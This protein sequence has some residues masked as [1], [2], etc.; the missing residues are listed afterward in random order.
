MQKLLVKQQEK[1]LEEEEQT[2]TPKEKTFRDLFAEAQT[3][4][5]YWDEWAI[6]DFT[7]ELS[8]RMEELGLTRTALAV[9]IKSS[10]AYVT[11][12]L[13]GDANFTLR[14]MT[15]LAR[16]VKSVLRVHLAPVGSYTRWIDVVDN[17]YVVPASNHIARIS[18]GGPDLSDY[19]VAA[20][21]ETSG[22][23]TREAVAGLGSS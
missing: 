19:T 20:M 18:F 22:A 2:A 10:P 1:L 17:T 13:R 6:G 12:I 15:K 5:A 14:S 4:D 3:H 9:R 23:A 8:R 7:E 11:K 21:P 16:A